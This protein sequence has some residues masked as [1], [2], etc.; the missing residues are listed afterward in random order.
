MPALPALTRPPLPSATTVYLGTS[1]PSVAPGLAQ[2]LNIVQYYERYRDTYRTELSQASGVPLA[3]IPFLPD[4]IPFGGTVVSSVYYETTSY[5]YTIDS[6]PPP[7]GTLSFD[8]VWDPNDL[9][10][11]HTARFAGFTGFD[12]S[13]G[14]YETSSSPGTGFEFEILNSDNH[15]GPSSLTISNLKLTVPHIDPLGDDISTI[16]TSSAVVFVAASVPEADSWI[17]LLAGLGLITVVQRVTR[18]TRR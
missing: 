2:Q 4:R 1:A 7:K 17:M 10:N 6:P 9:P 16:I 3:D 11:F 13:T 12:L 18:K 5:R 8:A 15:G 14:H